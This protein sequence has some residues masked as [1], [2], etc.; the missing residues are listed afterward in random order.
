MSALGA[1]VALLW[2]AVI[3]LGVI[4]L[5]LARQIGVLQARLAPAGAL[6]LESGPRVGEAA[7]LLSLPDLSGAMHAIG[8]PAAR[9]TLLFFLS[10]SCPV[11]KSLLPVVASLAA[12]EADRVGVLLAGDGVEEAYRALLRARGV[13]H[14]PLVLSE[15]LGRRL[16]IP[17][18]PYAVLVDRAGR[19]AAQGLVNTR[20][21]LESLLTAQEMQTPTVQAYLAR[22]PPA[23]AA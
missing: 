14:L 23:A 19:I 12:A 16:R 1:S 8:A 18:L 6:A 15:E 9:D 11:C 5:A 10:P 4:C 22:T 3:V 2:V 7:P 21:Q 17:R 13:A 20:E